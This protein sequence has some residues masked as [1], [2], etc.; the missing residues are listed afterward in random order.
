MQNPKREAVLD[1]SGAGLLNQQP[2]TSLL[3]EQVLEFNTEALHAKAVRRF[4]ARKVRT[5]LRAA[6]GNAVI[7]IDIGGDKLAASYF[8]VQ[9]GNVQ[10][11]RDIVNRQGIG[12]GR[13]YL[14]ALLE[15]HELAF[16]EKVPVGISFAG[17]TDGTR[18]LAAPNL[19]FFIQEFGQ[20]YGGDFANLFPEVVVT[21]DAEAGIMAGALEAIT[22][23]PDTQDVIYLINGSG[24]GG[25]VLTGETIFAAEPGHIK[26]VSQLNV[27]DQ[28]K[29]CGLGGA[30][31]VCIEAVAASKA[32]I[33]DIWSQQTGEQLSGHEIA[34]RYLDGEQLALQLYDNSAWITA[35]AIMGM[36]MAFQ[37][38]ND[39]DRLAVVCHG[40]IFH[41]P[42]YG[43]RMCMIL[44][45][46]LGHMPPV[47]FTK[48]FS[49]N[50][51]LDGGAIAAAARLTA[52]TSQSDL[53]SRVG[54]VG[55]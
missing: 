48:D 26:V 4:N 8:T 23:Y 3:P 47:L 43:D 45:Q 41:V 6:E 44:G 7:V 27:F 13:G 2:T 30:A 22:R 31:H 28:H 1:L 24:L 11:V 25:S 42:G 40:G 32:G 12:G 10:R 16:R 19:P 34:A 14:G 20:D 52:E 21:N 46:E 18:L 38:L 15:V 54:Q 5:R 49:S 51:C 50:T 55:P 17:P 53:Q 33:E 36:A 39:P 9:N 35:H 37:L 29:L